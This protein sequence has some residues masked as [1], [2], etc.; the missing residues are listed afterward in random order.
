ML[1]RVTNTDPEAEIHH[2]VDDKDDLASASSNFSRGGAVVV[3]AGG[4]GSGMA[5]LQGAPATA[6]IR[7]TGSRA[8]SQASSRQPSRRPSLNPPGGRAAALLEAGM[9]RTGGF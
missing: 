3:R 9:Q 5:G 6:T 4:A 7:E 2:I 1:E 8:G